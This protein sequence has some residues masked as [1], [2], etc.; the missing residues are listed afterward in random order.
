MNLLKHFHI[1]NNGFVILIQSLFN[2]SQPIA[3]AKAITK[4]MRK[5][6][7]TKPTAETAR[8]Y[9]VYESFVM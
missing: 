7:A 6:Q 3:I 5:Q 1:A 9:T 2:S 4:E 8:V